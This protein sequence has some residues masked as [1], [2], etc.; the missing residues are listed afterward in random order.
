MTTTFGYDHLDELRDC[1][2]VPIGDSYLAGAIE[3][4][5]LHGILPG[6]FLEAMLSNDLFGAVGNAVIHGVLSSA[7]YRDRKHLYDSAR[8]IKKYVPKEAY[9]SRKK[10]A[11]WSKNKKL[12]EQFRLE[13]AASKLSGC[14]I[15]NFG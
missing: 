1:Y 11:E 6:P 12:R 10:V 9:G 2:P 5:L 8:W 7:D 4:Y 15:I 14:P 13:Y 3:G